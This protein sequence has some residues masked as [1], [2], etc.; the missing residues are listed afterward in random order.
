MTTTQPPEVS[1]STRFTQAGRD[2]RVSGSG[3]IAA[4]IVVLGVI[5]SVTVHS[6][7]TPDNLRGLFLSVSLIGI[8]AVGLSLVTIV[9]KI[10]SLSIP[11]LIAL[12]TILFATTLH[13][14]SGV[15]LVLSVLLATVVGVGQLWTGGRTIVGEGE[16]S[17]LN[18]VLLGFL[19]V[20][21]AFFALLT[22]GLFWWHRY[23][24]P[25]RKLTLMG[26]NERAARV[27]GLRSWPLVLL[28]FT[29]SG[30]TTGLA[31]GLQSGQGTLLLG[32]SFGFDAIVAVVVGGVGIKGG[33][34]TPL[35]AA[36]GAVFV[37]LLE[38]ILSLMG[39]SY[40]YQLVSKGLL[41]LVA[42]TVMG[43][44][45]NRRRSS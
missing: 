44:S 8:V 18:S 29:V 31:A 33:I 16:A 43:I 39:L 15:A 25:G 21:T 11:A 3:V 24:V 20:Q 19:P 23:T 10:F 27:S 12:C 28:A 35:G 4:A 1:R 45:A 38:N 9:G 5:A 30:A 22:A 42:V 13:L 7:A 36:I 17:F 6:F 32:A 40:Q 14:G 2:L 26:L 37:G 34:G 41:V